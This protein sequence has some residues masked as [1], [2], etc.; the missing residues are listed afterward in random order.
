MHVEALRHRTKAAYLPF[1]IWRFSAM[2]ETGLLFCAV[3]FYLCWLLLPR[4]QAQ[5]ALWWGRI[6]VAAIC[7]FVLDVNFLSA[8]P[9]NVCRCGVI[10]SSVIALAS[11]SFIGFIFVMW[12]LWCCYSIVT[13][14]ECSS[15]LCV[16]IDVI[17]PLSLCLCVFIVLVANAPPPLWICHCNSCK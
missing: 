1:L 13:M 11:S 16:H 3:G 15:S 2:R 10:T 17:A 8:S 4:F 7:A 9:L 5:P 12:A 14:P 6:F